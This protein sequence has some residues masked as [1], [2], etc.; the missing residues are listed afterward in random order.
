MRGFFMELSVIIPCYNAADTIS[1]QL[2]ALVRQEWLGDWEIIVVNN[3]ST[4]ASMQIAMKYKSLLPQLRIID[5]S[6][7][8]GQ[9]YALNVGVQAAAG[10][11]LA[12]CDADDEV[13]TGWVE[14]MRKALRKY[15]FVACRIDTKKLNSSWAPVHA[16]EF[17][18][19]QIWY[20][21]YLPHAGGG[22][23]GVKQVLFEK[24]GGFDENLPYLHDTAFCFK[25]QS[26]GIRLHFIPGAVV[27][28]RYRTTLSGTFRQSCNYAEYN[29]LLAKKYRR[30][31]TGKSPLQL[32]KLYF[33]D[34]GKVLRR[35]VTLRDV[36]NRY[37][38][39]WLVGRQIG[40]LRGSL[41]YW[42]LP[43]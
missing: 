25:L 8:Q 37:K 38:W 20:P 43:V 1:V 2:E 3:R 19:Q 14:A 32:W 36:G 6:A 34:W 18:L 39:M 26:L 29:V 10:Q 22:T 35:L 42:A 12:F 16:Q 7:R 23:F 40:R 4:D 5:A 27:H 30:K 24:V 9:P 28:V 31:T 21:P 13:G 33:I 17:G 15:D 41:K 11:S